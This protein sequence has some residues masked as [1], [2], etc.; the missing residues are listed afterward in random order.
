MAKQFKLTARPRSEAGRNAVKQVRARGGIPAVIYG[1]AQK[2][3]NIEVDRRE[4]EQLLARA[5]GEHL[6]VDLQINDGGRTESRLSIIQEVQHHPVRRDILHVDFHAVSA[7]EK[8]EAEVPVEP[9]GEPSGVKNFGGIL[10][11]QVRMLAVEALPQNLPEVIHVD[12]SAM[13]IGDTLHVS[14]VKLPDGVSAAVE[15]DVVVFLVSEPTVAAEPVVE[16]APETPEVIKEKKPE[17]EAGG[18][19]K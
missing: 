8:I 15:A 17:A 2:P 18:E 9:L 1:S 11:Q 16:E 4:I 13:N 3:A 7:T 5:A 10:Q 19:K 14:D 6:V 12:V